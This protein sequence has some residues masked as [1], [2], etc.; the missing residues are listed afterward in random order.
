LDGLRDPFESLKKSPADAC[1]PVTSDC[2][3]STA[4][5][6]HS[7]LLHNYSTQWLCNTAVRASGSQLA[8]REPCDKLS[9]FSARRQLQ[10]YLGKSC[11]SASQAQELKGCAGGYGAADARL[12][13]MAYQRNSA[14]S[15]YPKNQDTGTHRMRMTPHAALSDVE[16]DMHP[17][18]TVGANMHL[19]HAWRHTIR[20]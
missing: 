17:L 2:Q 18:L 10:L 6:F 19:A 13:M 16:P 3:E 4:Q 5:L 12:T 11:I 9:R 20:V 8:P 14:C 15:T 7:S 1:I